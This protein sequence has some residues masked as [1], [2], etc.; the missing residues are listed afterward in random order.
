M[1]T[2][3]RLTTLSHLELFSTADAVVQYDWLLPVTA[4]R[5]L[6]HLEC[7]PHEKDAGSSDDDSDDEPEYE[8]ADM[9]L[10]HGVSR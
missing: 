2:I 3:A 10:K 4:M 8:G 5:Q 1:R 6:A 7:I 9:Y